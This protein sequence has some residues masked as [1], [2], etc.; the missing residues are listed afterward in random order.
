MKPLSIMIILVMIVI[1]MAAPALAEEVVLEAG[2]TFYDNGTCTEQDGTTGLSSADGECVTPADYDA[3]FSYEALTQVE[4][5][6]PAYAGRSVADVYLIDPVI[7]A[8]L[9]MLGIGLVEP[10]TFVE[11][12]TGLVML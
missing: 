10:F 5:Q 3:M 1:A 11:T 8:S 7:P 6:I 4:S 2:V 9:R 12:V